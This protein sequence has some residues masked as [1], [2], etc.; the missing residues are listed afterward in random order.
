VER[1]NREKKEADANERR[2][3]V[4]LVFFSEVST[5]NF[6]SPRRGCGK[7]TGQGYWS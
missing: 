2:E 5:K 7:G 1:G 6:V 4:G 3:Y